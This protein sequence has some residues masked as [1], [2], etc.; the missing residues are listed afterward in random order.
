[1]DEGRGPVKELEE[2]SRTYNP[3]RDPMDEGKGPVK[4]LE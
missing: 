2:R 4:E 3:V 1:M